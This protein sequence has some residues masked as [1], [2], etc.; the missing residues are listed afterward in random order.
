MGTSRGKR[1]TGRYWYSTMQHSISRTFSIARFWTCTEII[2]QQNHQVERKQNDAFMISIA[3]PFHSIPFHSVRFGLVWFS[4]VRSTCTDM[5]F[6]L[7]IVSLCRWRHFIQNYSMTMDVV[8]CSFVVHLV[9]LWS[10]AFEH[11]SYLGK[12]Y[13]TGRVD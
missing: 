8:R 5:R 2:V 11:F 9:V 13:D 1:K 4:S 3:V 7:K 12:W 10:K 6:Q